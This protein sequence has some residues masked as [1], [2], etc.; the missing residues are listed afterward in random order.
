MVASI[1]V[2]YTTFKMTYS[3]RIKEFGML[4]SIGMNRK[5]RKS[6]TNKESFI[7][8]GIGI[9][10]GFLIG[11]GLSGIMIKL[12]DNLIRNTKGTLNS[13]FI[14]DPNT[15]LYMKI[16]V[17][18]LLL[19]VLVVYVVIFISNKMA[20][21]KINKLTPIDAI[22][23]SGN[24]SIK[25]KDVKTPK[26]IEKL[27]KEEGIIAY[28]NIRRDKSKY[29]TIV[30]SL[31]ISIILFLTIS[32]ILDTFYFNKKLG[33]N[34]KYSDYLIMFVRENDVDKVIEYLIDN[35]LIN[36]YFA[37]KSINSGSKELTEDIISDKLKNM[38]ERGVF[39][40]FKNNECSSYKDGKLIF[41]ISTIFFYRRCL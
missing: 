12:L 4:S 25:P 14:I 15:R 27:F 20:I 38:L 24:I 34:N 31:S 17:I 7:L 2:I 37:F 30:I 22:R 21:R 36:K 33:E 11:I 28:K 8:G 29:K 13:I 39:E 5:Q 23:N 16:P 10:L 6:I 40:E 26:I 1:A 32:G 19:T 41:T 9:L 3:E 18:V 35:N